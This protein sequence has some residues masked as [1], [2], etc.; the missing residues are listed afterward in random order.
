MQQNFG[1]G[2]FGPT[3]HRHNDSAF[4]RPLNLEKLQF[5]INNENCRSAFPPKQNVF[6]G[7]PYEWYHRLWS[8]GLFIGLLEPVM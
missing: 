7:W 5:S 1:T 8:N 6:I 3:T 2:Y 4:S